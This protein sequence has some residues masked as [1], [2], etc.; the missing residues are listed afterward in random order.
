MTVKL[1]AVDMDGTFLNE[2]KTYNKARFL[3]QYA[4][5]TAR[6]IRFVVASGNQYYQLISFFPEI[7]DDIAF[8]AENGAW[9]VDR[10]E[11]L[12][13]GEFSRQQVLAVLDELLPLSDVTTVLCGKQSAWL[14]EDAP[15]SAV[16]TLARHYHRL[17]PVADLRQVEDRL[18]KVALTLPEAQSARLRAALGHRLD[19]IVT[20]VASGFGFVDLIIP[21][22]H[23]A[24]GL[25][26]LQQQW[27]INDEEVLAFGDSGNDAEML[28]Q[29][30][31]S[32]AMANAR[33]DVADLARFRAGDH[34][35]EA[36]L[37]VIDDLLAG[38]GV[39]A[40]G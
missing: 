15:A 23:K 3:A 14:P 4:E 38:R 13:C 18:F 31:Y 9:V 36:V 40:A 8:V 25:R 30:G 5:L 1:V 37:D 24:S 22:L 39:F 29:A 34:N 2:C 21:G 19:G 27:Q 6:G 20:P 26:R 10:G 7:R 11:T 12:F 16:A 17:T 35:A 32:F 33:P 28:R